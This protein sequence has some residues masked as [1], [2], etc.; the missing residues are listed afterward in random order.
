MPLGILL[1][2]GLTWPCAL[3]GEGVALRWQGV[4]G[5]G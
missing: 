5:S 3:F 1:L 4:G 2:K